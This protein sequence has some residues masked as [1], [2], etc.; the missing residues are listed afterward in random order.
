[1]PN[2][3]RIWK[4]EV[5]YDVLGHNKN[6]PVADDLELIIRTFLVTKMIHVKKLLYIQYNNWNSTVDNNAVDINRRARLIRDF[7]DHSIHKRIQELGKIDW[8]WIEEENRSYK[9]LAWYAIPRH[10]EEEQSMNYV[11]E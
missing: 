3:A 4:R 11:Y 6:L 9:S 2:H 5:Y 8:N 1:M 10:G 7:Y